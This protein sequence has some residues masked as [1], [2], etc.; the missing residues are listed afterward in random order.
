MLVQ[1]MWIYSTIA[2]RASVWGFENVPSKAIK[3]GG[4][5]SSKVNED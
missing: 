2:G 1:L 4:A 5:R 3:G